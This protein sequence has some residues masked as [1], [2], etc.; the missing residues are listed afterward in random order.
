MQM[1]QYSLSSVCPKLFVLLKLKGAILSP[2]MCPTH[3]EL[4]GAKWNSLQTTGPTDSPII[5]R[6]SRMVNA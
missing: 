3:F 6:K 4:H 5:P 1:V 2:E